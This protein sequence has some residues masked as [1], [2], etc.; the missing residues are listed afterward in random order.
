MT[1]TQFVGTPGGDYA[2]SMRDG[3]EGLEVNATLQPGGTEAAP[4]AV[5]KALL[6]R[7][8]VRGEQPPKNFA[9]PAIVRPVCPCPRSRQQNRRCKPSDKLHAA[10]GLHR[11]C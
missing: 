7:A 10:R 9:Q 11:L 4:A 8:A 3:F 5:L 6:V 1:S 2:G